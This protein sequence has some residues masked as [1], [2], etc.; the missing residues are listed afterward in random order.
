MPQVKGQGT[1]LLIGV[2]CLEIVNRVGTQ[3]CFLQNASNALM[4]NASQLVHVRM[5]QQTQQLGQSGQQKS[6]TSGLSLAIQ[7]RMSYSRCLVSCNPAG[8]FFSGPS[9][10]GRLR[11]RPNSCRSTMS[12]TSTS[13]SAL[14][15]TPEALC[16]ALRLL[17]TAL[18][19]C[20]LLCP[21]E[22]VLGGG[23]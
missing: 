8:D 20:G 2:G 4:I 5:L 15:L 23:L 13:K 1:F 14:R 16:S 7:C 17:T 10:I 9:P 21:L 6:L 22:P 3:V 18:F 19:F 11:G 12:D